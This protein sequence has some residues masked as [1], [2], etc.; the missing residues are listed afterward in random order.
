MITGGGFSLI[1]EM[2]KDEFGFR[3]VDNIDPEDLRI[4]SK[5]WEK[6]GLVAMGKTLEHTSLYGNDL[7]DNENAESMIEMFLNLP[8]KVITQCVLRIHEEFSKFFCTE[9]F[10]ET[11][12]EKDHDSPLAQLHGIQK[13][14]IIFQN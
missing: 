3:S 9:Y 14:F 4:T 12:E 7:S 8:A 6:R 1:K 11:L 10:E 2:T 5:M 13:C